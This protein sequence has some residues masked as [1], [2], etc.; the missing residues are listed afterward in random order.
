MYIYI[1]NMYKIINININ[2]QHLCYSISYYT[3]NV[4]S[5]F[6]KHIKILYVK[7]ILKNFTR[8]HCQ[9]SYV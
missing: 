2:L 4:L 3:C 9:K 1:Y 5:N 8:R 6:I 7:L